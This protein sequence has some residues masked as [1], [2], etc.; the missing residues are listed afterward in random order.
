MAK[1]KTAKKNHKP[2]DVWTRC[3][4]LKVRRKDVRSKKLCSLDRGVNFFVLMLEQ[5]GCKTRYSCEGH[6]SSF[7]IIFAGAPSV[8]ARIAE[9][10]YTIFR[11]EVEGEVNL[12][13][14]RLRADRV[15]FPEKRRQRLLVLAAR[16][17]QRHFG[18]LKLKH[19]DAKPAGKTKAKKKK[20]KRKKK[21]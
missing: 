8:A 11:V 17:W 19:T 10:S 15:D 12:F 9:C 13:S 20:A 6:P 4:D 18:S 2:T 5:L 21:K 14:I 16:K 3:C 7:Y 1:K